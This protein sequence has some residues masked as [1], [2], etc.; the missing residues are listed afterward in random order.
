[1]WSVITGGVVEIVK[2]W[3]AV[4]KSKQD[5][6]AAYNQALIKGEQDWDL[7]A[8]KAARFSWKDEFITIIWFGPLIWA[9]FDPVGAMAWVGFL[10]ALPYFYQFVMFGIVAASFGLRWF[11]KSQA[12][13]V[14]NDVKKVIK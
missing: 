14:R 12:F 2:G 10:E 7:E 1:M 9:M 3:F 11:F 5:A 13:N 4:K 8:M 6:E